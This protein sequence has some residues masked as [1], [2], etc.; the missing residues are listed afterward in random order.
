MK[1]HLLPIDLSSYFYMQLLWFTMDCSIFSPKSD[2][3]Y[4]LS[5]S[6]YVR[7]PSCT[8]LYFSPQSLSKQLSVER[9]CVPDMKVGVP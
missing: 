7:W 9:H 6:T 5:T 3:F 8:S 1:K 4:P 2:C